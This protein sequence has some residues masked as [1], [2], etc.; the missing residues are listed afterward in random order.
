MLDNVVY[1]CACGIIIPKGYRRRIMRNNNGDMSEEEQ[2]QR[3]RFSITV[4]WP[5]DSNEVISPDE[6]AEVIQDALSDI[7]QGVTVE[8]SEIVEPSY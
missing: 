4:V 7:D 3:Q 5:Q 6:I 8:V 1:Y 2:P